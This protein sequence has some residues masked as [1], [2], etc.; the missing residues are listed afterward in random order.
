MYH[1]RHVLSDVEIGKGTITTAELGQN[2]PVSVNLTETKTGTPAGTI[3][4]TVSGNNDLGCALAFTVSVASFLL[5]KY[6]ARQRH[7]FR[8]A[9]ELTLSSVLRRSEDRHDQRHHR[10]QSCSPCSHSGLCRSAVDTPFLCSSALLPA[11]HLFKVW[12]H[13]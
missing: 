12:L 10:R 9:H 6:K 8:R 2:G 1:K 7:T 5:R 11:R 3:T 13:I 4:F